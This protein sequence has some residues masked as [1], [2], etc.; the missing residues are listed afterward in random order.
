M[1]FK[2]FKPAR[3]AVLAAVVGMGALTGSAVAVPAAAAHAAARPT[4]TYISVVTNAV[5]TTSS[6]HVHLTTS[7]SAYKAMSRGSASSMDLNLQTPSNSESHGWTFNMPSSFMAVSNSG[8]GTVKSGTKTGKYGSVSMKIAPAGRPHTQMCQG[9]PMS[10]TVR[11][12]VAGEYIVKT[13]STGGHKWGNVGARHFKFRSAT[14]TWTYNNPNINFCGNSSFTAPCTPE[15]SFAASHGQNQVDGTKSGTTGSVETFRTVPLSRPKGATRN[16]GVSS[17]AKVTLKTQANGNATLKVKGSGNAV[18]SATFKS[19]TSA[20]PGS[21]PCGKNGSKHLIQ[22][23]WN[24]TYTNGRPA[25]TVKGQ[26]FGGIKVANSKGAYFSS[27]K[28]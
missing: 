25:L 28:R 12:T 2:S 23:S 4:V 24:G 17:K 8:K 9:A 1:Q 22:Q 16:D 10:K 5:K 19:T 14:L 18:G 20:E 13:H 26:I 11:V 15:I 3:T 27:S 21:V 7:L 6:T